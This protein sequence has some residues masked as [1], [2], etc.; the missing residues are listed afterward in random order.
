MCEHENT[1]FVEGRSCCTGC[2]LMFSE[3]QYVFSYHHKSVYR[4]A[5]I[6]SR[7]K[8]FYT[9]LKTTTIPSVHTNTI[10]DMFGK[11][12]FHYSIFPPKNRMY[13]FNKN[14]VLYFIMTLM[15]LDTDEVKTLKDRER[16]G[17]Q[18]SALRELVENH[19][20]EWSKLLI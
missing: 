13:F 8:R 12:E 19:I 1:I 10:M 3:V 9:F 11:I 17:V 2:G 20:P 6:Y 7:Q 5:P 18:I 16:V 15:G 14:V 4:K